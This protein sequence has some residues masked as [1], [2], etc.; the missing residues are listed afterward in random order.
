MP[1]ESPAAPTL[2]AALAEP[3]GGPDRW[4]DDAAFKVEWCRKRFYGNLRR[5]RVLMILRA[6]E[7]Q[8]QRENVR[9]EPVL[10][11]NFDAL[12][13]EHI[14][15]QGWETHW[16]LDDPAIT[17]DDRNWTLHGIGNLTLIG[18]PLNK[19]MSHGPWVAPEGSPSKRRGL[20]EHSK[21]DLNARLL[22]EHPSVWNEGTIRNRA[23]QLF[24]AAVTIWPSPASLLPPH[25]TPVSLGS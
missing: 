12:E 22:R 20:Q 16:T 6:I 17:R 11:F 9:S 7:E 21:L 4:P 25:E 14:M 23:E 24:D 2:I 18:A 13:I 15:P 19:V 3:S 8:Y 10:T 5:N 1:A